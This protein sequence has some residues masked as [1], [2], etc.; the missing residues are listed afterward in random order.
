MTNA[1][2]I[3][4]VKAMSGESADAVV[5]AFLTMSGDAIVNRAFPFAT[6]E[7]RESLT[8]PAAE[9]AVRP[10]AIPPGGICFHNQFK[11]VLQIGRASCRERV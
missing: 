11:Q 3:G 7:E 10:D 6:E 9:A 2:M 5:S 1:E 4:L 8:V